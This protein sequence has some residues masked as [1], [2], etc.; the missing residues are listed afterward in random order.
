ML[1]LPGVHSVQCTVP[2]SFMLVWN[3]GLESLGA[4]ACATPAW[5][6]A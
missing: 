4:A 1:L 6:V 5:S 3:Y 2:V